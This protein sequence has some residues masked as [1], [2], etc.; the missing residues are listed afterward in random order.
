MNVFKI[1]QSLKTFDLLCKQFGFR[2]GHSD[3][4]HERKLRKSFF[5]KKKTHT[6]E[7]K[8]PK[9]IKNKRKNKNRP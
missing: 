7:Q 8:N 1:L 4:L 5:L 6:K 2:S 3:G 9:Q